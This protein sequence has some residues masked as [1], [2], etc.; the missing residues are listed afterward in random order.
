[1][2]KKFKKGTKVKLRKTVNNN[3]LRSVGVDYDIN[4]LGVGK[5]VS[6]FS[7]EYV[8]VKFPK[9][10]HT[11]QVLTRWLENV[12]MAREGHHLTNIFK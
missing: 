12:D 10:N 11:Y 5:I 9:I 8:S 7:D 4:N 1:M 2:N 3:D 6:F